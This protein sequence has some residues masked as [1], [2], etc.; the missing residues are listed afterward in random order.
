MFDSILAP[1]VV[2][3]LCSCFALIIPCRKRAWSTVIQNET[4]QCHRGAC[5]IWEKHLDEPGRT[6]API[7]ARRQAETSV[8]RSAAFRGVSL[9]SER[10]RSPPT[11]KIPESAGGTTRSGPSGAASATV[12]QPTTQNLAR[13]CG[14]ALPNRPISR[15]CFEHLHQHARSSKRNEFDGCRRLLAESADPQFRAKACTARIEPGARPHNEQRSSRA[16]HA[17]SRSRARKRNASTKRAGARNSSNR[18]RR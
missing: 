7:L 11:P 4:Y 16:P 8:V 12:R 2:E 1:S 13:N 17:Q 14:S 9:A 15:S 5:T 10:G 3:T 18:G 6:R